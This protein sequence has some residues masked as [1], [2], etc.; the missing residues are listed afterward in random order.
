MRLTVILVKTFALI[1]SAIYFGKELIYIK[2]AID[3]RNVTLIKK[4]IINTKYLFSDIWYIL[5]LILYSILFGRR[6]IE[7]G[8]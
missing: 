3:T 4:I 1:I 6:Q 8:Q 2:S 7:K 5:R